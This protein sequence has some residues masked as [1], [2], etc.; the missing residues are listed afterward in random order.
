MYW[1]I[2]E[3]I[4][5]LDI[6]SRPQYIRLSDIG[7]RKKLSVAYLCRQRLKLFNAVTESGTFFLAMSAMSYNLLP[8]S[9]GNIGLLKNVLYRATIGLEI[10][11][12]S[13]STAFRGPPA[14]CKLFCYRYKINYRINFSFPF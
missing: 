11:P 7:L 1:R 8:V 6:R 3:T 14:L 9:C 10:K 5:L 4:G 2:Q 12:Q 13:V